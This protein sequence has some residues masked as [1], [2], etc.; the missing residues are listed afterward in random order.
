M[1]QTVYTPQRPLDLVLLSPKGPLYRKRGGIFKR[2]LRYQPLTLTTL[3]ALV[4]KSLP[5]NI[6]L[7]D[8]SIEELPEDFTADLVAM[9]VI[10]GNAPRAYE[11]AAQMRAKNIPVVLGGPHVTLL[12]QEA[13]Q[14]ADTVCTGYSEQSWP[15]LIRDF[16]AGNM[17]REY[18][19]A[20]IS[21]L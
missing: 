16:M 8:E 21:R 12:P 20:R 1:T 4:P 6:R 9:T 14:H 15:Q 18:R 13:L 11:L 19:R 10:T 5:V 17:Q 7:I 3:S 2:S